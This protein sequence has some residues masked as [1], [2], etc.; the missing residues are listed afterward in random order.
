MSNIVSLLFRTLS[1]STSVGNATKLSGAPSISFRRADWAG[2]GDALHL[3][4]RSHKW[5]CL[6]YLMKITYLLWKKFLCPTKF[7]GQQ[8]H[9]CLGTSQQEE[10]EIEWCMRATQMSSPF[11]FR[12]FVRAGFRFRVHVNVIDEC[13]SSSVCREMQGWE[14]KAASKVQWIDDS[15]SESSDYSFQEQSLWGPLFWVLEFGFLCSL[16]YTFMY[17]KFNFG[18]RIRRPVSES[19]MRLSVNVL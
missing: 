16:H 3:G 10:R 4:V 13:S 5:Y 19:Q 9:L 15:L 2:S 8:N 18:G 14:L 7:A 6:K 11:R 12:C 17:F 1:F